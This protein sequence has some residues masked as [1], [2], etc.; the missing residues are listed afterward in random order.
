MTAFAGNRAGMQREIDPIFAQM[1]DNRWLLPAAESWA[2]AGYT[3]IGDFD[4]A[5]PLLQDSLAKPNG[6]TVGYLRLD[7]TWDSV[8][9]D[10]RFQ[11]AFGNTVR[12]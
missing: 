7:P 10:P 12:E 6:I 4:K 8:R 9:G 1:G 5:L 2:A 3:L 11:K